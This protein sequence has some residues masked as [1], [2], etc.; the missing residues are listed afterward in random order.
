MASKVIKDIEYYTGED[1][2]EEINE[3]MGQMIEM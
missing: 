2:I 3:L 1:K